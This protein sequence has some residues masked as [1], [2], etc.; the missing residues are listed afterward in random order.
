MKKRRMGGR[1]VWVFIF[2]NGVLS[3]FSSSYEYKKAFRGLMGG[4]FVHI[5]RFHVCTYKFVNES[6]FGK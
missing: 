2:N 3:L 5:E 1:R 4:V 6:M